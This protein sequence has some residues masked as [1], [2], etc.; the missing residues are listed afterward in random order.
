VIAI[1]SP[2]RVIELTLITLSTL[3]TVTTR[4]RTFNNGLKL[5][6]DAAAGRDI[7]P[8]RADPP[9]FGFCRLPPYA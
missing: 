6:R 5:T 1:V 4:A 3:L 7:L 9:P 8:C 2:N